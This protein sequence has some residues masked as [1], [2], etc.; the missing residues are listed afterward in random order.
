[1]LSFIAP[2]HTLSRGTGWQEPGTLAR[3]SSAPRERKRA[4]PLLDADLLIGNYRE[5]LRIE[6]ILRRWSFCR[7]GGVAG[8]SRPRSNR[9]AVPLRFLRTRTVSMKAVGEHRA[10]IRAVYHKVMNAD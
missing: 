3:R 2:K 6:C 5:L 8:G 9:V 4:G 1:M 10:A 7:R